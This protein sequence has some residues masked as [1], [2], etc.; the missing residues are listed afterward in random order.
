MQA[1]SAAESVDVFDQ[2]FFV[3]KHEIPI[4]FRTHQRSRR[5]ADTDDVATRLDLCLC[6]RR[7]HADIEAE[8]LPD[9]FGIVYKIGHQATDSPK[10]GGFGTRTFDPAFDEEFPFNL[11]GKE[12]H[13]LNPVIHS[14]ARLGRH[15]YLQRLQSGLIMQQSIGF[16]YRGRLVVKIVNCRPAVRRF[17]CR[18]TDAGNVVNVELPRRR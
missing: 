7:R 12:F 8:Q 15:R 16:I 6:K 11:L 17:A 9:E 18:I 1:D 4:D 10:V 14:A 2:L 13:G 5:I 3:R